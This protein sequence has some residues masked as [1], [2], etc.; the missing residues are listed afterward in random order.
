MSV[1][2]SAGVF[3]GTCVKRGSKIGRAL[4]KYIDDEGGSPAET[5]VHGVEIGMVG[6]NWG[7]DMW[8]TVQAKGSAKSYGRNEGDCPAPAMMT[9]DPK[10]RAAIESFLARVGASEL[11]IGWHFQG[12]AW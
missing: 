1:S 9:E 10:W 11:T 6:S 7:G 12:S 3:F 5:S 2:Y 8:L 4:D